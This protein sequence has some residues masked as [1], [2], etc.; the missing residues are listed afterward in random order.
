MI[1]NLLFVCLPTLSFYWIPYFGPWAVEAVSLLQL[2]FSVA[3]Y[4][5]SARTIPTLGSGLWASHV[6]ISILM[7]C[8]ITIACIMQTVNWHDEQKYCYYY[9]SY[10]RYL[11]LILTGFKMPFLPKL[12]FFNIIAMITVTM[13]TITAMAPTLTVLMTD[14]LIILGIVRPNIVSPIRPT[15]T[16]CLP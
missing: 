7:W 11:F 6:I 10:N 1:I 15:D 4:K 16:T 14:I 2:V 13:T 5:L 12:L 9:S 8:L 3:I